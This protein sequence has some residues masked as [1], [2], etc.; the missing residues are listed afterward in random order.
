MEVWGCGKLG[1]RQHT[2][3]NKD[4]EADRFRTKSYDKT[5]EKN[6][7]ERK[8]VVLRLFASFEKSFHGL[9][10]SVLTKQRV[11]SRFNLKGRLFVGLF[12]AT[13]S[14]LSCQY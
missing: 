9:T 1:F 8:R 3:V 2:F 4:K 6:K 13:M 12:S 14:M 5:Y 10:F 11:P 7:K